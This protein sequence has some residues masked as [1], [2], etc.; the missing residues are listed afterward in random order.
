[1]LSDQRFAICS[2]SPRSRWP[3]APVTAFCP[4]SLSQTGSCSRKRPQGRRRCSRRSRVTRGRSAEPSDGDGPSR[5]TTVAGPRA[6]PRARS[7]THVCNSSDDR[8]LSHGL[9]PPTELPDLRRVDEIGFD[10]ETKD[11]GIAAGI[12]SSWPWHGGY[13]CRRQRRLSARRGNALDYFPIAHPDSDNFP[14]EQVFQWVKDHVAAGPKFITFNG[15][16]DFGWLR[17]EAGILMPPRPRFEDVS[18]AEALINENEFEYNLDAVCKRYGLPGKD[19]TLLEAGVQSRRLQDQQ[20]DPVSVPPLATAGASGRSLCRG[21]SGAD[22]RTARQAVPDPRT[23]GAARGLPARKRVVPVLLE[24]RLRGIKVNQEA[25]EQAQARLFAKRDAALGR[26]SELIGTPVGLKEIRSPDWKVATFDARGIAYPRTEK[27][28]PSFEGGVEGWM[29]KH[30]DELP[31]LI[32]S[33]LN[34]H[35]AADKFLGKFILEHIVNG[36]IHAEINQFRT[37]DG[38]TVSSRF[39]YKSPALQQMPSKDEELAA[40]IRGVFEPEDDE[41]LGRRRHQPA[42]IP[43]PGGQ[44]RAVRPAGRARDGRCL[45]QRSRCR[46]SRHGRELVELE[47]KLAKGCNFAKIYGMGVP[48]FAAKIGKTVEEAQAI[49]AK[50]DAKLPFAKELS[51]ICSRRSPSATATSCCSTA[52]AGIS[53]CYEAAWLKWTKD[54]GPC[55]IEEARLRV[56]DPEHPWYRQELRRAGSYK[57]L[58]AVIQ[59]DAARQTKLW[60]RDVYYQTGIVPLLQM[61]DSL[62]FSVKN[63]EQAEMVARLGCDAI[64]LTVPIR[65]DMG[66]GRSWGEA[67][68]KDAPNWAE[69]TGDTTPGHDAKYVIAPAGATATSRPPP[70]MPS[71]KPTL[72]PDRP[73]SQPIAAASAMTAD[74]GDPLYAARRNTGGRPGGRGAAQQAQWALGSPSSPR[75][76]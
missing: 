17:S 15:V 5:S 45:S 76:K 41:V 58:N 18:A 56:A 64:A 52:P 60:L 50:Y 32:A 25:A 36:R 47:R 70:Q 4:C 43:R 14:R 30:A 49:M 71:R 66:F 16:Y 35:N 3:Q 23:R 12:G 21:R 53:I 61:H 6:P 69:L 75:S 2:I 7:M 54:A 11:D 40:E 29:T 44:G 20:E 9:E 38:G 19:T 24:M 31:R 65:V 57:A 42:G 74:R 48:A 39:S 46:R 68:R 33:A 27:G 59:G 73:A 10:I 26:I 63:F 67:S 51:E 13:T 28:N 62:S 8:A 34:S 37:E 1:M 22:A 55:R 72:P